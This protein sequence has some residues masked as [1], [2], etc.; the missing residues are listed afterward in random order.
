MLF[1]S[2]LEDT[3]SAWSRR[4]GT[5]KI[6]TP[7]ASMNL[8]VN[9]WL[10]YQTISCRLYARAAFYQCGGAYGFRDQ[11]QDVLA[12]LL[13][14]PETARDHIIKCAAHQFEEGDV[15]HWWH[16]VENGFKG[17]RTRFSDDLLWLPYAVA[18]YI[19]V[20]GDKA[21]LNVQVPYLKG[22]ML[23]EGEDEKYCP[24]FATTQSG[25]IREHC[26]RAIE[27]ASMYGEHGLP[28]MGSGDWNDGMNKV[29]AKGKGE[30]VWLG[31]FLYD[32]LIKFGLNANE[33]KD[34]LN[35]AW[36]GAWYHRAYTDEGGV[37]GS[38]QNTECRIDA[39]AQAW[40]VISGAG[41]EEQSKSAM[42]S[43]LKHLVS[44]ED[45]II[46]LL[47][48]PFDS[49][50]AEVGYIKGY[51]PGVRENG[52]QYS[53]A[54]AWVILAFAKLGMGDTAAE[55][56]SMIN[57]VNHS[58]TLIEASK[59]KAEPYVMAAD[60]YSVQSNAGRGGWTW[61]TGAS[62]WMYRVATEW[63]LGIQKKGNTLSIS[64]C[65]PSHWKEFSF[66]YNNKGTKY[67]FFV[68]NPNNVS[69]SEKITSIELADDKN[70]H[71]IEIIM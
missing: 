12:L 50:E 55:L 42:D 11:L 24:A 32:I 14:D 2:L 43:V 45:G 16:E 7:D 30:S 23:C 58:R 38:N 36:D 27:R 62:G 22:D 15:Q 48:P 25:T 13:S 39:I 61:Y 17:I 66:E 37:I 57:P 4:V 54:A 47:T 28:L 9:S 44:R 52:G 67:C 21:L 29:G 71:N 53:H 49:G 35:K 34:N 8:M 68:K 5:I 18:E 19:R 64:P 65:I 63:I 56:Y 10:L 3:K 31:W 46:K 41:E 26:I 40:S 33:L 6:N 1:R 70:I 59:Y 51:V 69:K 60:V 20:T